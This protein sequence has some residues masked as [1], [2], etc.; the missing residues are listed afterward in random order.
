MREDVEWTIPPACR[1]TEPQYKAIVRTA[2]GRPRDWTLLFLAGN[3]GLRVSEVLHLKVEHFI[4][5]TG[6]EVVRRKKQN[7]RKSILEV[8][9]DVIAIVQEYVQRTK[10]DPDDWL[11]PGQS[12]PCH[13]IRK[14]HGKEIGRER[15]CDGGHITV[16]RA[17]RIWDR[18]ATAAGLKIKGRGIHTLRHYDGTRFYEM[19]KDLRAVQLH[20]GHSSPNITQKYADV[21]DMR[22]KAEKV[23]MSVGSV[24]WRRAPRGGKGGS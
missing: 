6:V 2:E 20:L 8:P 17:Q 15:L 18:A 16:R 7:L 14:S 19:T 21:V 11:F 13:R 22:E 24:P 3:I 10:L 12:G 23:G 5:G 9:E 1:I 4:P